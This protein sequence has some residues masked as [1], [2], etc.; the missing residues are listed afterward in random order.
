MYGTDQL[1]RLR[2]SL[3]HIVG[4]TFQLQDGY[5]ILSVKDE[6]EMTY[7]EEEPTKYV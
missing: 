5:G 4:F 2:L 6:Q 3:Y 1:K 7:S